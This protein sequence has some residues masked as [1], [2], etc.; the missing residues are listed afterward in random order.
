MTLVIASPTPSIFTVAP[1]SGRSLIASMATPFIPP[2][3]AGGGEGGVGDVGGAGVDDPEPQAMAI[4][5]ATAV[6][7]LLMS[8][9]TRQ[10]LY[11]WI[12]EIASAVGEGTG[13][14]LGTLAY[15]A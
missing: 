4:V 8:M 2:R 1:G 15:L 11:A 13:E 9:E 12:H 5:H 6:A 10:R 3:C 7:S 14:A